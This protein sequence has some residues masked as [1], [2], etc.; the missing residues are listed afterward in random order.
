MITE[1]QVV[2]SV[3]KFLTSNG[4]SI[5]QQLT[6]TQSGYDIIAQKE[7]VNLYVEAKGGTSSKPGTKRYGLPFTDS[8]AKDHIAKSIWQCGRA[9][10]E[11]AECEVGIALP[12]EYYHVKFI[13]EI[14]VLL[15]NSNVRVFWVDENLVVT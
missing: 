4:W 5:K 3:A 9:L 11:F 10:T 1:N 7:G 6:T 12:K 8:Q 14:S 15:N 2:E 13:D